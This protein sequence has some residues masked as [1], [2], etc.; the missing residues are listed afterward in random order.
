MRYID[1]RDA[2][3]A[4]LRRHPAGRTWAQLRDGLGLPY[5]RPCPQWTRRLEQEI[6]LSRVSA[7]SGR[8]YIWKVTHAPRPRPR[9]RRVMSKEG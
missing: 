8:A 7:P 4:E 1:F 2:I 3:D 6:G 9:A 5:E